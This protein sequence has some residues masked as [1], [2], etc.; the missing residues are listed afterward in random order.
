VIGVGEKERV[1]FWLDL[2]KV[3]LWILWMLVILKL[4]LFFMGKL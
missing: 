2:C 3:L 1:E 4:A